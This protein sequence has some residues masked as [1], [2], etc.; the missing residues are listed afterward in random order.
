MLAYEFPPLRAVFLFQAEVSCRQM[1][2]DA[3]ICTGK[4]NFIWLLAAVEQVI[5]AAAY[6]FAQGIEYWYGFWVKSSRAFVFAV[7]PVPFFETQP[8]GLCLCNSNFKRPVFNDPLLH[9]K[10]PP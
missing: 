3:A 9:Q 5:P 6:N 8:A 7:E 2:F 4:I 10:N 1:K